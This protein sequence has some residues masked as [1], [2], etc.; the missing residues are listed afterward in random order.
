MRTRLFIGLIVLLLLS[1]T[2][3]AL[4]LAGKKAADAPAAA[5]R[6]SVG[7]KPL[8]EMTADDKYK[9]EDGGLYGGGNNEPPSAHRAAARNE[10]AKIVPRAA[11][12]E[13]DAARRDGRL[14]LRPVPAT[15]TVPP[16]APATT[17]ITES[18]PLAAMVMLF[19]ALTWA[20]SSM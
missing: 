9:G 13:P 11:D 6:S 14:R 15:A 12:G 4:Q 5:G 2:L 3:W 16:L 19:A 7:L 8:T 1:R 17:E 18:L 10:T 20:E